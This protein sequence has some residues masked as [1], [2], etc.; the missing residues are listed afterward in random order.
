ML[1][2]TISPILELD[3]TVAVDGLSVTARNL[4]SGVVMTDTT[5]L[6]AGEG[7]FSITFVD[8]V[9]NQSAKVGDVLEVSFSDPNGKVGVDSIRYTVTERD[10]QLGRIA[11]GDLVAYAIPTCTELLQNWPNPFNPETW[12]PFKLKEESDVAITIYDINGRVIRTLDLGHVSAGIHNT[13]S[14]AAYWNGTNDVGEHVASGIYFYRLQAGNF[15]A[16]R[17][18]AILK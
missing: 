9:T 11:L 13:K 6:I 17:K 16:L 7:R 18:M 10:I 3:G 2:Q 5:G 12:I 1:D 14:K 4:S 8:F 15:S